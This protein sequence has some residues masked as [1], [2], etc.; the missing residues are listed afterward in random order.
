MG[1]AEAGRSY[2]HSPAWAR[3]PPRGCTRRGRM[4]RRLQR[5]LPGRATR[6]SPENGKERVILWC[7]LNGKAV[8]REFRQEKTQVGEEGAAGR[9]SALRSLHVVAFLQGCLRVSAPPSLAVA[10][11]CGLTQEEQKTNL[12]SLQRLAVLEHYCQTTF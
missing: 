10:T 7:P 4:I 9:V 1:A 5:E 2:G 12:S 8:Q 3:S 6:T 11:S